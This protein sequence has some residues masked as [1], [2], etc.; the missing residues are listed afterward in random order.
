MFFDGGAG[1][2]VWRM[3]DAVVELPF[4]FV[5]VVE[6]AGDGAVGFFDVVDQVRWGHDHMTCRTV[7]L[8]ADEL[9]AFELELMETM[10]QKVTHPLF[11]V[12][13]RVLVKSPEAK[14]HIAALKSA[15]DGYS[16]LPYQSLKAKHTL[17]VVDRL[18]PANYTSTAITTPLFFF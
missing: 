3:G 11:Q 8:L 1:D 18:H 16:V 15:L 7:S 14:Q 10:H 4:G 2:G 5:V 12:N 6:V 9:S 13:I 17:P